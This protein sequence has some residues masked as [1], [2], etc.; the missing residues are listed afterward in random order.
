MNVNPWRTAGSGAV[1]QAVSGIQYLL[2]AR[3]HAV[4]TDGSFGPA[5][6]A[7]VIAF[8]T[9]AGLTAD[10]VVGPVT[11]AQLVVATTAGP[12]VTRCGP[13]S[14]SVCSPHPGDDPLVV[15]GSYGPTTTA[16]VTELQRSWG[17]TMDGDAG[18]ETWSFLS[19]F[20][21][22]PRPWPLVKQGATQATNW[23]VLAAQHLLRAKGATIAADGSFGPA[24]GAAMNAFQQTLR[25]TYISTTLGQLDWPALIMTVK[26][27]DKG[28]AV[29]A[30]QTLVPGGLTVDGSFGP[31]DR[32]GGSQL[33]V[34]VC[35]PIRRRR[36]P[37][38]VARPH[39]GHLRLMA[40]QAP[41]GPRRMSGT[42]AEAHEGSADG[43]CGPGAALA[44]AEVRDRS[45]WRRSAPGWRRAPRPDWA[46]WR[47]VLAVALVGRGLEVGAD[48]AGGGRDLVVA[49]VGEGRYGLLEDAGPR[50]VRDDA[51]VAGLGCRA[52]RRGAPDRSRWWSSWAS[53]PR[54]RRRTRSR[55]RPGRAR[56][57]HR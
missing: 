21:P 36:R 57:R 48:L 26:L 52:R 12:R 5:T 25:A 19:T 23:R 44:C 14:S 33:P 10:G 49:L 39:P 3:G 41:R 16:R 6:R 35:A 54:R 47:I 24:S 42:S 1:S 38:H 4:A 30:V 50:G 2:K 56:G 31:A 53:N 27:G 15:D 46:P 11:W 32:C 28:E 18:R 29:K 9:A 20:A 17:L 13:S 43:G 34:D 7:A 8:Q 51:A 45:R 40:P 55:T 22:G 37:E